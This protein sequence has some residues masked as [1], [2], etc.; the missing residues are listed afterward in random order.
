MKKSDVIELSQK[1][2]HGT[3]NSYITGYVLSLEFT[4]IAYVLVTRHAFHNRTLITTVSVLAIAQF[5]V[6]ILFFL[7]LG[8]ETKPRWKQLVFWMMLTFVIIIVGGSLWVMYN[9]NYHMTQEQLNNYL[10]NQDGGI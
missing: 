2:E 4:I 1:A 10:H 8:K 3:L 7:H 5:V 6:Q 9:L